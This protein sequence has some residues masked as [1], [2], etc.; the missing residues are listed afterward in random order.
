MEKKLTLFLL[1]LFISPFLLLYT[2]LYIDQK[3]RDDAS[4]TRI[5]RR[6]KEHPS[7]I[8]SNNGLNIIKVLQEKTN[9]KT[10]QKIVADIDEVYDRSQ[11]KTS[12]NGLQFRFSLLRSL[13][14]PNKVF[15]IELG[16]TTPQNT[17]NDTVE[18]YFFS[19]FPF[20]FNDD[21]QIIAQQWIKKQ[22]A[23]F[24]NDYGET[25]IDINGITL[26]LLSDQNRPSKKEVLHKSL[27]IFKTKPKLNK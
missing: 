27:I 2:Y 16:V 23:N 4:A 15:K 21:E 18:D 8:V 9:L 25:S 1:A 24:P 11:A 10:D 6:L 19:V 5:E 20:L 12:N 3:S 26:V 7:I 22:L 17:S 14:D 13:S